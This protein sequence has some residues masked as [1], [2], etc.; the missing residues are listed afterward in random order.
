MIPGS[1][2]RLVETL[3]PWY[4]RAAEARHDQRSHRI[5]ARAIEVRVESEKVIGTGRDRIRLA[6]QQYADGMK[7][8]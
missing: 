5:H 6:Y 8:R 7:R 2:R 1:L 4:D 3:L